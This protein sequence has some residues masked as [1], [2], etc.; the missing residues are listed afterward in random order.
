MEQS[1][2]LLRKRADRKHT[3]LL[4]LVFRESLSGN[5][6]SRCLTL[7]ESLAMKILLLSDPYPPMESTRH[8]SPRFG[9]TKKALSQAFNKSAEKPLVN[10]KQKQHRR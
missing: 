2:S 5:Q 3:C 4:L 6:N 7:A 9:F 8:C 1:A 10:F